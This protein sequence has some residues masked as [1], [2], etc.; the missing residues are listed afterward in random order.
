[1][2]HSLARSLAGCCQIL[3]MHPSLLQLDPFL[4]V[5][6][7]CDAVRKNSG[8]CCDWHGQRRW[9]WALSSEPLKMHSSERTADRMCLPTSIRDDGHDHL[10]RTVRNDHRVWKPK[11]EIIWKQRRKQAY[12]ECTLVLIY[13]LSWENQSSRSH[14]GKQVHTNSML[15]I[16]LFIIS[17]YVDSSKVGD[18]MHPEKYWKQ[19]D[20]PKPSYNK[21]VTVRTSDN[22]KK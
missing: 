12:I 3:R 17:W 8:I 14:D 11:R 19:Q 6:G 2:T 13:S 15:D 10:L 9:R 5:L 16:G 22:G 7:C 1:M 21:I 20:H 4:Q 18:G